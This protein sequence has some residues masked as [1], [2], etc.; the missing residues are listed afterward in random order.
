MVGDEMPI[1]SPK[2]NQKTESRLTIDPDR[3]DGYEQGGLLYFRIKGKPCVAIIRERSSFDKHLKTGR[4]VLD[5]A[6]SAV[7]PLALEAVNALEILIQEG[8]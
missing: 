7:S 5:Y 2:K 6:N 3:D 1:M 8:K 4:S